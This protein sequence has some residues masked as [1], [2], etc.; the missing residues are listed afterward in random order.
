MLSTADSFHNKRDICFSLPA[1]YINVQSQATLVLATSVLCHL[2]EGYLPSEVLLLIFTFKILVR[3]LNGT[4]GRGKQGVANCNVQNFS[5]T[6]LCFYCLCVGQGWQW[7][8]ARRS[9]CFQNT[10]QQLVCCCFLSS[11][12]ADLLRFHVCMSRTQSHRIRT[13]EIAFEMLSNDLE[14]C[15]LKI[16]RFFENHK[17]CV[18]VLGL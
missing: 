8:A 15:I 16:T 18:S 12:E 5:Y 6:K 1:L 3:T 13:T 9:S 2:W 4:G 14:R 7:G 11:L 10:L 17:T